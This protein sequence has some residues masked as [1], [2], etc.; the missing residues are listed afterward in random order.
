MHLWLHLMGKTCTIKQQDQKRN[1]VKHSTQLS[2]LLLCYGNCI[3]LTPIYWKLTSVSGRHLRRR[4][5]TLWGWGGRG[6]LRWTLILDLSIDWLRWET[7]AELVQKEPKNESSIPALD[8]GFRRNDRNRRQLECEGP[9]PGKLLKLSN[10]CAGC[11]SSVLLI[12]GLFLYS[13]GK[14]LKTTLAM[15]H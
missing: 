6:E 3:P 9:L 10:F 1:F 2:F 13:T 4:P 12:A 11:V 15:E 14:L 5:R 7:E 8:I